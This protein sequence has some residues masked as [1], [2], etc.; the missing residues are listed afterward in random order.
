MKKLVKSLLALAFSLPLISTA[1][2]S[3]I[4]YGAPQKTVYASANAA[5]KASLIQVPVYNYTYDYYTL[6]ATFFTS[7]GQPVQ[8]INGFTIYPY[9]YAQSVVTYNITSPATYVC[10]TSIRQSDGYE[11]MPPACAGNGAAIYI[12]TLSPTQASP[13]NSSNAVAKGV[14]TLSVRR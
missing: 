5:L 7:Y 1:I 14:P 6:N 3:D 4:S 10:V 11:L 9:G 12:T 2:A 8:S 13:S